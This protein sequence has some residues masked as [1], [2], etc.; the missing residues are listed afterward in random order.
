MEFFNLLVSNVLN[1]GIFFLIISKLFQPKVNKNYV[2]CL[3]L[4]ELVCLCIVNS[5]SYPSINAI[6]MMVINFA[7]LFICYHGKPSLKVYITFVYICFGM[8]LEMF[9]LLLMHNIFLLD[10]SDIKESYMYNF[11]GIITSNIFLYIVMSMFSKFLKSLSNTKYPKKTILLLCL[12]I[13]SVLFVI[14]MDNFD[15]IL[16]GNYYTSFLIL[17]GLLIS[18]IL[19]F[20]IF[21]DIIEIVEENSNMKLKESYDKIDELNYQLL[22]NKYDATRTVVHDIKKHLNIMN[23]FIKSNDFNALTSYISELN[24]D[25]EKTDCTVQTS[26]KI[27]NIVMSQYVNLLEKEHIRLKLDID[28][29]NLSCLSIL[30]QNIIFSNILENA[31]ESCMKCNGSRNMIIKIKEDKKYIIIKMINSCINANFINGFPHT[32]KEDKDRH[33]LGLKKVKSIVDDHKGRIIFKYHPDLQTFY[34]SI[35]L[36]KNCVA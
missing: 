24:H 4:A 27:L 16:S 25:V 3:F 30:E 19:S 22:E 13:T 17:V 32:L 23:Q 11:M 36:P 9:S 7:I 15:K 20:Y 8:I 35:I 21:F 34:T 2:V 1:I 33:G 10:Y 12:P 28:E 18:N 29:I 31:I 6:I 26:Q 14:S 5:F